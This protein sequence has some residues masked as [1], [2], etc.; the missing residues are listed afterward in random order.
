MRVQVPPRG[1]SIRAP[2]RRPPGS[3]RGAVG[4]LP[5]EALRAVARAAR[6]CGVEDRRPS[7]G[8]ASRHARAH[9][10]VPRRAKLDRRR[11]RDEKSVL[12][13]RARMGRAPSRS[14]RRCEVPD[15]GRPWEV[16]DDKVRKLLATTLGGGR[17]TGSRSGAI[18][19]DSSS[20][21]SAVRRYPRRI[22]DRSE[23]PLGAGQVADRLA[24]VGDR[25][26][27]R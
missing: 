23:R 18:A 17:C 13:P 3:F 8:L 5:F 22:P 2:G 12:R 10:L 27:L 1:A 14:R 19:A 11:E 7:F 9:P 21:S 24:T 15:G 4:D 25:C 20:R 26:F 6:R 16:P